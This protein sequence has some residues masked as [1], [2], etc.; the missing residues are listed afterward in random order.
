MHHVIFA[1]FYNRNGAA[2]GDR[3]VLILDGRQSRVRHH[4]H[5]SEWARKHGF[6][7]YRLARGTF[8]NPFHLTANVIW[9]EEPK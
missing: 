4:A 8:S 1:E 2:C 5:A 3:S 7:G 6:A 9:V